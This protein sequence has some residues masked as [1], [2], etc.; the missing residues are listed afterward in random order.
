MRTA[1][2]PRLAADLEFPLR[3]AVECT[4]RLGLPNLFTRLQADQ[5][6]RIAY[7]GV[8]H[9]RATRLA[10]YNFKMAPKWLSYRAG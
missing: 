2:Q 1:E 5:D 10:R 3:D 9:H 7:L 4:P 6:T 8:Q